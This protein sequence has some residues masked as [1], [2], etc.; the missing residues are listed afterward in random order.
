MGYETKLIIVDRHPHEGWTYGDV[1]AEFN[2][3]KLP[4]SF[5][6]NDIFVEPIDFDLPDGHILT[7]E[8]RYGE[9]CG[10]ARINDVINAIEKLAKD[11]DY[12]RYKP[13][14]ALLRGFDRTQWH[15]LRVVHWGY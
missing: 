6:H 2:L 9:H 1:I 11:D 3:C 14:L 8:D 4:W 13:C 7:R 10:M 12:R 15:D 5:N